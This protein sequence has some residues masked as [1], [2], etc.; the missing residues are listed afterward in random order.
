M[1][2]LKRREGETIV[3]PDLG[4]IVH[5]HRVNGRSVSIGVEAAKELKV[6]RGELQNK[7]SVLLETV[8]VP[9]AG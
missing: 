2:V 3:L 4:V 5:V 7:G 9:S 1:L 6:L 8:S